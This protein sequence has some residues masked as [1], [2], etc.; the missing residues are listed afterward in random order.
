MKG[1]MHFPSQDSKPNEY[2]RQGDLH[3]KL[4]IQ[5]VNNNCICEHL[6]LYLESTYAL[7]EENY[8][9]DA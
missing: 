1:L 7:Q 4:R 9:D 5:H 6:I 8:Y 3:M 2:N